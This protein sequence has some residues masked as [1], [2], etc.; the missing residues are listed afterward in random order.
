MPGGRILSTPLHLAAECGRCEVAQ[1]LL[2]R[3]VDVNSRNVDGK[4]P[5][6][7]APAFK[8]RFGAA[9]LLVERGA[10]VNAQDNV[11]ET[12]LLLASSVLDLESVRMLLDNGANVNAEDNRG[13]TPLHR[14]LW[15]GDY[16]DGDRFRAVELLVER[17]AEVNRPNNDYETSLHL[18]SRDVS[19]EKAWILLK[20]GADI[21]AE[22]KQ[23]QTPFQLVRE[24]IREEME[25][26]PSE[27]AIRRAR[28][29]QGVT[30]MSLFYGY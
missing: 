6:H 14:A 30:L 16:P 25:R 28:R 2:E 12:P 19:L 4:T 24:S 1:V 17:D 9:Q 23:G 18:A 20:H 10:D 15:R 27:Y 29:A 11:H 13:Q 8:H 22:N 7:M 3:G 5:L 26:L 21:H